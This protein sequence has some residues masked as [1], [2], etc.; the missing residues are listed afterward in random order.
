[1][2]HLFDHHLFRIALRDQATAVVVLRLLQPMASCGFLSF[3][4]EENHVI[5]DESD[6]LISMIRLCAMF[7]RNRLRLVG[8]YD[9][10]KM[11]R[12]LRTSDVVTLGRHG[13]NPAF[14]PSIIPLLVLCFPTRAPKPGV[15]LVN[16][17]PRDLPAF[18]PILAAFSDL[19]PCAI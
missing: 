11:L 14:G 10:D 7:R 15:F 12:M 13:L 4:A 18:P 6:D 17:G 1:V 9:G 5:R 19:R 3:Q 8:K 2:A 16:P